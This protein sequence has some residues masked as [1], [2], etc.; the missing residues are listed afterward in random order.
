MSNIVAIQSLL[1]AK[2]TTVAGLPP[3]YLENIRFRDN[4]DAWCR[5]TLLPAET[6][7][8]T[9]GVDGLNE[10]RGIYQI[11]LFYPEG[12]GATPAN[13]IADA[14]INTFKRGTTLT[15]G[16]ISVQVWLSWRLPAQ[17][18]TQTFYQLPILVRYS[19]FAQ[20]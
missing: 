5:A 16:N 14:V 8:A 2:L 13:T 10:E 9:L 4:G 6:G 7:I 17:D 1:D 15:D 3:L 11:D 12:Y 18:Y 19:C 20:G